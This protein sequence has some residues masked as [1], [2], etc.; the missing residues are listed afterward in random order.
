MKNLLWLLMLICMVMALSACSFFYGDIKSAR[1]AIDLAIDCQ[2]DEALNTLVE[3]EEG[4]GIAAIMADFER[5]AILRD[6]GRLEEAEAVKLARD[7]RTDIDEKTK[8]DAEQSILE[9]VQRI[10][11]ERE[12]KTGSPDCQ[13]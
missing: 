6:A 7:N 10:Q 8:N 4:G 11:E 1:K 2:T 9:L 5:E 12:K 13:K 3:T